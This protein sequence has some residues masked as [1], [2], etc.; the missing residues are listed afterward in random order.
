MIIA[1]LILSVIV[2]SIMSSNRKIGW[3][4]AFLLCV[5]LSPLLGA[6]IGLMLE[7]K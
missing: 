6:I 3:F 1:W 7:R 4:G 5:I 2:A